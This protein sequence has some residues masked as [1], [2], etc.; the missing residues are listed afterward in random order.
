M[1]VLRPRPTAF[2]RCAFCH[3]ALDE[4]RIECGSCGTLLHAEYASE[5]C[6]TLGC[7]PVVEREPTRWPWADNRG[8]L[9]LWLGYHV[10][11]WRPEIVAV[12]CAVGLIVL[13]LL[14]VIVFAEGSAI[15]PSSYG[16]T[17]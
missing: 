12:L 15:W 5:R 2:V 1:H 13:F 16:P 17:F 9:S 14:V 4:K 3:D 11:Y 8:W 7:R 10:R 6:P